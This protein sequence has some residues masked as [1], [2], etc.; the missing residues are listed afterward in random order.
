MTKPVYEI[1][2]G[3]TGWVRARVKSLELAYEWLDA[4]GLTQYEIREINN[5]K[6]VTIVD[7]ATATF[8]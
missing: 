3:N 4:T 7:R 6:T 5:D 8:I 1:R 2:D